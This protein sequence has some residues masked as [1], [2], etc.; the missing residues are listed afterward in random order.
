MNYLYTNYNKGLGC[1]AS[2]SQIEAAIDVCLYAW[3]PAAADGEGRYKDE[4]KVGSEIY[5]F[6]LE[7]TLITDEEDCINDIE[8]GDDIWITRVR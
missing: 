8:F 3:N 7:C 5:S 4:V 2:K 1:K 6:E